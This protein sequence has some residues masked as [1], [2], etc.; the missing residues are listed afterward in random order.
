MVEGV[1]HK[2]LGIPLGLIALDDSVASLCKFKLK[3]VDHSDR[4]IWVRVS[5][6]Q[7]VF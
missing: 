5:D 1:Q 2:V 7:D 6:T 4:G 3:L